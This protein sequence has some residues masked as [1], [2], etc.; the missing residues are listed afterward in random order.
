MPPDAYIEVMASAVPTYGFMFLF[1]ACT[2]THVLV[3]GNVH[4]TLV[5]ANL[6]QMWGPAICIHTNTHTRVYIYT[7][8]IDTHT[9]THTHT[10][11]ERETYTLSHS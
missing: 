6:S 11:R 2:E 8:N 5:R 9:H 10:Q 1:P 3:N 4:A 7:N